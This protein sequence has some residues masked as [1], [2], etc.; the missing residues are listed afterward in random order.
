MQRVKQLVKKILGIQSVEKPKPLT[1]LNTF[2]IWFCQ[3]NAERMSITVE[4]STRRYRKSWDTFPAGHIGKGFRDFNDVCYDL[5]L[6][7]Y[8][9]T[10]DQLFDSYAFYGPMHFLRMLSYEVESWP[11]KEMVEADLS[12]LTNVTILDFGCGLA[13]RSIALAKYLKSN[14]ITVILYLADIPTVRREFL[15]WV[16]KKI[17]VETHFLGCNKENPLPELPDCHF[18][19]ATEVFEHLVDPMRYLYK[20]DASIQPGGF[21][22]TGVYDHDEEYMHVSPKLSALRS[23][24]SNRKYTELEPYVLYRK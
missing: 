10:P 9:D 11:G 15:L 22:L 24:L 20:M 1:T 21:L 6:P 18:C 23:E 17:G 12:E 2:Q 14:E 8:A 5:Y 7:F 3:W 19:I 16:G 13:Q 4:E